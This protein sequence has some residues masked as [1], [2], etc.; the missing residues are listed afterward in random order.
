MAFG[1]Y[2]GGWGRYRYTESRITTARM[3]T[4]RVRCHRGRLRR[5]GR[6]GIS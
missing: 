2:F 3:G 5:S 6:A 4:D 1:G